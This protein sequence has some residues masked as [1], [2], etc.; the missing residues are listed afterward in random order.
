MSVAGSIAP[1]RIIIA[2]VRLTLN[3]E[4]AVRN[5]ASTVNQDPLLKTN[6]VQS[7]HHVGES[8]TALGNDKD[9]KDHHSSHI[10]I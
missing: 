2:A 3:A 5:G 6:E 4:S 7:G 8:V 10:E 9:I 1:S